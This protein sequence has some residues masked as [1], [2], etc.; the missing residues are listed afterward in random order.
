MPQELSTL[1]FGANNLFSGNTGIVDP[2]KAVIHGVSLITGNVSAEGHDLYVD[3]ICVNQLFEL[4]KKMGKVPVTLDHGGGIKSVNGF[5]DNFRIDGAHLRGDWNLLKSHDETP[6]MLERAE[7]M[8]EGFGMSV[9]FKGDKKGTLHMGQKCARAEK[10]ISVD[11]VTRPAAN[12][13]GMFSIPD[14]KKLTNLN[15]PNTENM[16]LENQNTNQEPTM[17]DVLAE[18]QSLRAQVQQQQETIASLQGGEGLEDEPTLADLANMTR[19]EVEARGYDVDRVTQAVHDAIQS[20]E[21]TGG[22]DGETSEEGQG[23]ESS[24]GST[25][26][27]LAGASAGGAEGSAAFSALNQDVIAL[28]AELDSIKLAAKTE[29]EEIEFAQLKSNISALI[30]QRDE[31]IALSEGLSA[32]NDALRVAVQTGTRPVRA[33]VDNGV[34]MFGA[35]D[36]GELHQFQSNVK[37][38]VAAGKT[39]G[40][41]IR[42][43]IKETPELHQDWLKSQAKR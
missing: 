40:E 35:N 42:F 23:S 18:L 8:P 2:G 29:A 26:G 12:P 36:D 43:C 32:E 13:N 19:E 14:Q 5:V 11:C 37:A 33:G 9:A 6:I 27:Q 39:Q 24:E 25:G 31:A 22:E 17:S 3:G 20:G 15:N 28:K 16:P 30:A 38:Q 21:L 4:A 1:R 7:R 41:A 34:R 10:L